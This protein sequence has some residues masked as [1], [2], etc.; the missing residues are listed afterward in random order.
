MTPNPRASGTASDPRAPASELELHT[1][2]EALQVQV[3]ALATAIDHLCRALEA[4]ATDP[5]LSPEAAGAVEEARWA[6]G[7]IS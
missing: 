6:L 4:S 7:E 5:P 2:V 3:R 1:N